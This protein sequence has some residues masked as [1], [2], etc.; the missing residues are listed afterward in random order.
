MASPLSKDLMTGAIGESGA[1]IYP[2]LSPIP[3]AEAEQ[4]GLDFLKEAG[5]SNFSEFKNI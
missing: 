1:G 4:T 5:Y 3:L 2:T